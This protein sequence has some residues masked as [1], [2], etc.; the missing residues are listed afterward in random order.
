MI[1]L[2]KIEYEQILKDEQEKENQIRKIK[3]EIYMNRRNTGI[4]VIG[5]KN[6]RAYQFYFLTDSPSVKKIEGYKRSLLKKN[7][8]IY[9]CFEGNNISV[10]KKIL[11]SVF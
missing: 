9:R 8:D 4:V 1:A 10:I 2:R 5:K 6:D 11:K 7:I 3:H